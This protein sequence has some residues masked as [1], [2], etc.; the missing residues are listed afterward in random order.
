MTLHT[1]GQKV[2][3]ARRRAFAA[4]AAVALAVPLLAALPM[5]ARAQAAY[6]AKPITIVVPFAAGGTTDILARVMAQSLGTEFGQTV[7][8]DNKAGA[9]GNIGAQLV[10]R[11]PADGYTLLMGTVGT[12]AINAALY[13][14]MPFDPVKDFAPISRVALVPNVMV[15]NASQPYK[16]VAEVIAAAKAGPGKLSVASSG[17]GTSIHLSAE[18]FKAMTGT[19]I[20]HVPY[21]G[22]S[23]AISDLL[24]NQ[25]T[26]MF[27]NLPSAISHIRSGKLRALAV[28]SAKRAPELPNV[29]TV[30]E[31]GVKG[32]EATSWFG[33]FAPAGTPPAIIARLD[34]AVIKALASP[35]VQKK[36]GEQGAEPHGEKPEQFAAYIKAESAKWGRVVKESGATAE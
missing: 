22:S 3:G 36:L 33:L 7:I 26:M 10:A 17:I 16:S 35:E 25:V 9:G 4:V 29:P 24:G 32:F 8:V 18:L 27:D 21:K 6:P 5:A 23:P 20:L 34:D 13:K 2:R 28:T 12:H 11:A 15:V 19:D 14:K 1:C 30:A 31:A